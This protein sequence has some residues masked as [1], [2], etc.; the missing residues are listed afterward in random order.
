M[1]DPVSAPGNNSAAASSGAADEQVLFQVTSAG[2]ARAF[3]WVRRALGWVTGAYVIALLLLL[4]GLEWWGERSWIFSV[5]LYSPIQVCL[6]PL[7][8][9]TPLCLLFRWRLV[10]WHFVA[11]AILLFGFMTFRWASVPSPTGSELKAVTFN[12]GESNRAQFMSFLDAEK[13]DVILLQDARNYGAELARK[14]GGMYWSDLGQFA[15]L[16]KFPIQKAAIVDRVEVRGQPVAA[17]YEIQFQG[18][19]TAIYSV[20]LPTPRQQL[21]RFLGGRRVLGDLVGHGHR[22]PAYGNYREWL[23]E[24][25]R[26]SQALSKALAEEKEPMIVG[27]DFNT[28][29]H[30]YIYH[31]FAGEM[32]DAF[33]H[34]GR[35][36]GLTFPGS[37]HNPISL[38]GPWLRIDYFFTGR[39]WR[40][41]ECRPEPGRKSQ[42]KAVFARFEPRPMS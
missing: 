17:R 5:L 37:T 1:S 23:D 7:A 8:V 3:E 32:S 9:L 33:T 13:P 26:L 11:A 41:T 2:L 24:R 36:W 22:E 10:L 28:P 42:H 39:G 4:L 15:F 34:V 27:G 38:F 31:L 20:H 12:F 21:S 35:G 29:D 18:R 25:L 19:T 30:G 6:L 16:S 40:V 14:I